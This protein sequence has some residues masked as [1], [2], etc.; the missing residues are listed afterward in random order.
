MKKGALTWQ[1]VDCL[2]PQPARNRST[3]QVSNTT[4]RYP[5]PHITHDGPGIVSHA[6]H[7]DPGAGADRVGA[8]ARISDP[9]ST[10]L[11]TQTATP[12]TLHHRRPPRTSRPP[13]P[14]TPRRYRPLGCAAG[15]RSGPPGIRTTRLTG[16]LSRLSRLAARGT[17]VTARH[18]AYQRTQ[19][20]RT[21]RKRSSRWCEKPRVTRER[22]RLME[23]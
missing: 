13:H 23:V 18:A 10:P 19:R 20:R 4:G 1:N 11:G 8:A 12:A 17:A 7:R 6:G 5:R 9:P 16:G 22:S 2:E 3:F 14:A 21:T 15:D